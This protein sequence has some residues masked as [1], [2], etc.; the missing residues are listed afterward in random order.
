MATVLDLIW[1]AWE[2]KYFS[3]N[4][5]KDSTALETAG[6]QITSV[7]CIQVPPSLYHPFEIRGVMS[8]NFCG[9]F[10]VRH[11]RQAPARESPWEDPDDDQSRRAARVHC[12]SVRNPVQ[13]RYTANHRDRGGP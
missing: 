6:G 7:P 3:E 11:I 4:Q 10:R 2:Q 8:D 1:G 5:K 13:P 9:S 12:D